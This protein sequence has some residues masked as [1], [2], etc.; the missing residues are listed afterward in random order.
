[1]HC[2]N[3]CFFLKLYIHYKNHTAVTQVTDKTHGPLVIKF[4]LYF[5]KKYFEA[6]GRRTSKMS[7]VVATY[8]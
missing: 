8:R 5:K 6:E 4:E 7:I 1:M 3:L 2:Y